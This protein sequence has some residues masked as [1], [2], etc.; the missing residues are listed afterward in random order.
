MTTGMLPPLHLLLPLLLLPPPAGA[1]AGSTNGAQ[2]N[3]TRTFGD[4][5][6]LDFRDPGVHGFAAPGAAGLPSGPAPPPPGARFVCEGRHCVPGHGHV[7]YTDAGCFGQCNSSS[8]RLA[9][10]AAYSNEWADVRGVNYVP[11]Y[12]RNDVQTWADYDEATVERELGYAQSA[13]FNAVR[14]FLSMLP[15]V[16]DNGTFLSRYDH[17]IAACAA[18]GIRPLIVI[19]DD[20][21]FDVPGVNR[22]SDIP[23]WLAT[24]AYQ[25]E[26]WM[27]NPGMNI[28]AEDKANSWALTDKFLGHL[29]GGHRSN[30]KR[31]LG[32]DVMNEPGVC[33]RP[34]ASARARKRAR[35]LPF[36]SVL[37]ARL[38]EQTAEIGV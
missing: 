8:S 5:M 33:A 3:M 38:G 22:T 19:F 27:A 18:K 16:A 34:H 14:V 25:T 2:L 20:D 24:K 13:G 29:A 31:L 23:A 12:S 30:D 32:Y 7:S 36:S 28:L 9:T 26:K 4:N 1:S 17:F 15:W 21:F 10:R 37:R 35:L 6:V 11:S